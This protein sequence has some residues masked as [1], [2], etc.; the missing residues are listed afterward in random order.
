[1]VSRRGSGTSSGEVEGSVVEIE[2][3]A[4]TAGSSGPSEEVSGAEVQPVSRKKS[5]SR[6]RHRFMVCSLTEC[7]TQ[8]ADALDGHLHPVVRL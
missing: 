2:G 1:M 3:P 6:E 8:S 5:R 4:G 7:G